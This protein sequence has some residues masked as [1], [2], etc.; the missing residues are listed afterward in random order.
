MASSTKPGMLQVLTNSSGSFGRPDSWVSRSEMWTTLVPV[1]RASSAQSPAHGGLVEGEPHGPRQIEQGGLGE[2]TDQA[3]IGAMGDNDRRPVSPPGFPRQVSD[4][5]LVVV[6]RALVRRLLRRIE[7]HILPRLKGGVHVG[8][9]S[10][11]TGV[12]QFDGIDPD[13]EIEQK[14]AGLADLRKHWFQIFRRDGALQKPEALRPVG[15]QFVAAV[16]SID[17]QN[18]A[19]GQ[20]ETPQDHGQ[21]TV[22]N[23]AV[24]KDD[25]TTLDRSPLHADPAILRF[26]QLK[27]APRG[28]RIPHSRSWLRAQTTLL[29]KGR[30]QI[31]TIETWSYLL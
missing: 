23:G 9:P 25:E 17:D 26:S 19:Q 30:D 2:M 31:L 29:I 8:N 7:D 11:L 28:R 6:F 15:G 1:A 24:A 20:L 14:V 27:A 13:R 10:A 18:A 21:H 12:G 3:W 22:P 5:L 16:Q 4:P